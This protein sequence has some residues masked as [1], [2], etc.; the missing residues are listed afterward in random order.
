VGEERVLRELEETETTE[1]TVPGSRLTEMAMAVRRRGFPDWMH[2][3]TPSLKHYESDELATPPDARFV[4]VSITGRACRLMCDHCRGRIL[5][6]MHPVGSPAEFLDLGR[7]LARRG[8]E[9]ILLTGGSDR[10][11]VVPLRPYADAI[12][13]IREDLGLTV[14]VHTGLLREPDAEALARAGVDAAMIDIIGSDETI[15]EVYHLD[16]G[17][18]DFERSLR[19][20]CDAGIPTA[21]HVV[22][23]I[24]YG[25]VIGERRAL[26]MISRLGVA[27]LVIVVLSPLPGTPME[28][29]KPLGGPDLADLFAEA[30]IAF[31]ETPVLLGCARPE[32]REKRGIDEAALAAG[33][34]GIAFP[35]DGI[36]RAAERLGFRPMLSSDCCALIFRDLPGGPAVA[37]PRDSGPGGS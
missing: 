11:G 16:A 22:V 4:P 6:S 18:G 23:G 27:S 28:S 10:D 37:S 17:V 3:F 33:F 29:V 9:G 12:R 35:A 1:S 26:D 36:V 34:N 21:P 15:R 2:F 30:R 7:R 32:G 24:H 5:E 20:L 14:I 8:V 19:L 13:E 25:R 31:P